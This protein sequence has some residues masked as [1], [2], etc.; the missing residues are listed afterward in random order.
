MKGIIKTSSTSA[1]TGRVIC[2]SIY[3][4]FFGLNV[5]PF[6]IK[7]RKILFVKRI[8]QYLCHSLKVIFYL[9]FFCF[10]QFG[11]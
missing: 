5:S 4:I 3:F 11:S 7:L 1:G 10:S 2:F 6:D 8:L 9:N